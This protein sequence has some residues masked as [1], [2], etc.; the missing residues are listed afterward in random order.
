MTLRDPNSLNIEHELLTHSASLNDFDVQGNYLIS[1]GFNDR[2]V[3]RLLMVYDLR[4]M[5]L[6]SPIQVAVD[7]PHL[8][9][10]LPSFVSRL[11]IVSPLGQVQLVHVQELTE[12]K[13]CMYQINTGG[14]QCLTFDISSNN[15]AMVFGDET[16]QIHLINSCTVPEPR[17][18]NFSRET[19]FADTIEPLPVVPITDMNFPLSSILLPHL[20]SGE[21]WFSDFPKQMMEYKYRRPKPIDPVILNT[22]KS[23][24]TISYAPNPR[25]TRFDAGL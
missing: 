22:M 20:Q 9:R 24:G 10:F 23:Q 15:Q 4:M 17:F 25:T 11:A 2:S 6:V 1:C 8:L 18:N 21:R 13:L 7:H 3:D 16:G 12:P 14:A 19:E 5:R